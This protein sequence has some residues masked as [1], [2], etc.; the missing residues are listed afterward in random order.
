MYIKQTR[1]INSAVAHATEGSHR[2][3]MLLSA[4]GHTG[5]SFCS[6][7]PPHNHGR[8]VARPVHTWLSGW[9]WPPVP[10]AGLRVSA[11]L[12]G[13]VPTSGYSWGPALP[14][15]SYIDITLQE[16]TQRH[17]PRHGGVYREPRCLPRPAGAEQGDRQSPGPRSR[18][19]APAALPQRPPARPGAGDRYPQQRPARL[20]SAPPR[21]RPPCPPRSLI[22]SPARPGPAGERHRVPPHVANESGRK[23][24]GPAAA[25]A[26]A[27]AAAAAAA[28]HVASGAGERRGLIPAPPGGKRPPGGRLRSSQRRLPPAPAERSGAGTPPGGTGAPFRGGGGAEGRP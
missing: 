10:L 3:T 20:R 19:A 11:G 21:R 26:P 17:G 23:A 7:P 24:A 14:G 9:P 25:P 12:A 2:Y 6:H 5:N 15:A 4:L 1:P 27:P 28:Y 22:N 16:T 18:R 8:S 13:T